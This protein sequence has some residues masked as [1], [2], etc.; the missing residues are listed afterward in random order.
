MKDL[1]LSQRMVLSACSGMVAASFCHPLDVLRVQLQ[2]DTEGG[3][4]RKYKGMLDCA[5]QLM[6]NK[7]IVNGLYPGI[8]AAYLRQWT[9]GSCRMGIYSYLFTTYQPKN[10]SQKLM[11]GMF[12]GGIGA[13]FGTPSELA[14]VRMAADQRLSDSQRRNYTGIVDCISRIARDEGPKALWRGC[15]VTVQ[16][17]MV[18]GATQMGCASEAKQRLMAS[19]YFKNENGIPI[20]FCSAFLASIVANSFTMPFDVVKSR[21]QNMPVAASGETPMYSGMLDCARKSVQAE[22]FFVL[23][24]GY[25][26]ALVK[27]APYMT[28]SLCILNQVTS[29]VTGKSAI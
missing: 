21:L 29:M 14:L 23:W 28:I 18:M 1:D 8:G 24:K 10:L 16:R 5:R 26:P 11:F 27:L 17:A 9:Y 12:S 4:A 15:V 6:K 25:N 20:V 13:V 2:I 22:G 19:G 7:G 3:Q